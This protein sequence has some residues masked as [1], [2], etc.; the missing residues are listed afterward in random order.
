MNHFT[1]L[2]IYYKAIQ[3]KYGKLFLTILS[4]FTAVFICYLI[5]SHRV[6]LQTQDSV[7][8]CYVEHIKKADSLY[9]NIL[10]YNKG[11][12]LGIQKISDA[13]LA[14]S[15]IRATLANTRYLSKAQS[16]NL[17]VIIESHFKEIE[18]LHKKFG[19]KLSRDSV[20]VMC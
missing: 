14:D 8:N 16:N 3:T 5:Y 4:I 6:F 11:V 2:R 18:S 17:A 10:N 13:T 20:E 9:L 19:E 15:L 1:T 12:V 7:K